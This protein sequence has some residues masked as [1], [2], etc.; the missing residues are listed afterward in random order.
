MVKSKKSANSLITSLI[1][2]NQ[3]KGVLK[4]KGI[5][6][7]NEKALDRLE[8]ELEKEAENYA[9][10][11]ARKPMLDGRKTLM[12][13]DIVPPKL[14]KKKRYLKSDIIQPIRS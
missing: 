10:F 6:R 12:E 9:E 3:L 14:E 7:F 8:Q 2:R 5:G 4:K 11:L 13:K 1:K